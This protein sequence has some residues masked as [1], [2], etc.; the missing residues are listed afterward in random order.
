METLKN[1][2]DSEAIIRLAFRK[3]IKTFAYLQN[4]KN[5]LQFALAR[6]KLNASNID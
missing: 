3:S 5:A 6:E 1:T 2:Q 4:R